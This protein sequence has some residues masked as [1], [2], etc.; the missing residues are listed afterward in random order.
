M[1]ELDFKEHGAAM[2]DEARNASLG[3][4]YGKIGV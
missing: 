4:W 1:V 3:A 2:H